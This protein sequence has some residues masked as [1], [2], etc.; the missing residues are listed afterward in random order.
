[1]SYVVCSVV[2]HVCVRGFFVVPFFVFPFLAWHPSEICPFVLFFVLV[3]FRPKVAICS[4]FLFSWGVEVAFR[5]ELAVLL[6][7]WAWGIRARFD[8]QLSCLF[9]FFR[10]YSCVAV[11]ADLAVS[12]LFLPWLC[13]GP[14]ILLLLPIA[15]AEDLALFIIHGFRDRSRTCFLFVPSSIYDTLRALR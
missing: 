7:C 8:L 3:A 9:F 4:F 15:F 10:V 14:C 5:E 6:S 2:G 1:M 11:Q 13:D 12:L